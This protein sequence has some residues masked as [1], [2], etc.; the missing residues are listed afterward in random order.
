MPRISNL[1]SLTT[2]DA[3]DELAIVDTSASVTKKITRSDFLKGA[4]LPNDT[5]TTSAITNGAVTYAKIDSSTLSFGNYSTSEVDTG[6]TWVDGKTIYKKTIN[7]G[8]L[9]NNTSKDVSLGIT[10]LD[11]VI[12]IYGSAINST[13]TVLPL[14]FVSSTLAN[15]VALVINTGSTVGVITGSDRSAYS[16]Y[17]TILYTKV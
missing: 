13:K 9:P 15:G 11:S 3:S 14:P 12:D 17:I 1:T 2:P 5:V 8:S 4:P 7:F 10:G 6:F 16:A